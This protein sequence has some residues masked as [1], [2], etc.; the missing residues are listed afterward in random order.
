MTILEEVIIIMVLVAQFFSLLAI[1]LRALNGVKFSLKR[2]LQ[3][4]ASPTGKA[5]RSLDLRS[6]KRKITKNY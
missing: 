5:N 4:Q 6:K 1:H 2:V 3:S